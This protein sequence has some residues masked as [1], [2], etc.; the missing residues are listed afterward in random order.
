MSPSA[1]EVKQI[2]RKIHAIRFDENQLSSSD[3]NYE[4]NIDCESR[5]ISFIFGFL[6]QHTRLRVCEIGIG[7]GHIAI[8]LTELFPDISVAAVE[9]PTREYVYAP[10]YKQLLE[11][12]RIEL[13]LA[14]ITTNKIPFDDSSFDLIFFAETMEHLSP[15]IIPKILKEIRRCLSKGGILILTTPNILRLRNR[16]RF[17]MG[18]T[19]FESPS[20]LIGGTYGHIREYSNEEV[21]ALLQIC[22]FEDI[23]STRSGVRFPILTTVVDRAVSGIGAWLAKL[24]IKFE[25]YVIVQACRR[26]NN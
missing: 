1:Y 2:I 17:L 19:V 20:V 5:R 10:A 16:I 22:G 25:D 3:P 14:D 9:A 13:R 26:E 8:P 6:P 23:N 7:Y 15:P 21:V 11:A 4:S 18:K 24:S 12:S